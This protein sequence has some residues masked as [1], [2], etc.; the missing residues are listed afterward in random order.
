MRTISRDEF[1]RRARHAGC[2]AISTNYRPRQSEQA[3][4]FEST[5]GELISGPTYSAGGTDAAR[6]AFRNYDD[7]AVCPIRIQELVACPALVAARLNE[8]ASLAHNPLLTADLVTLHCVGCDRRIVIDGI[9][10]II[11]LATEERYDVL[12][13]ITELS[14]AEWPINTPDLNIVC[15]CK[16][17]T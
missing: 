1:M 3:R 8:N 16:R 4:V 14:G 6:S 9:H 11:R 5:V 10:R 2:R 12:V 17:T 7:P 13:S 15:C